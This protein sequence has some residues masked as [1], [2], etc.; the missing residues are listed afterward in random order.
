MT[1]SKLVSIESDALQPDGTRH[2]EKHRCTDISPDISHL[3]LHPT[4][5]GSCACSPVAARCSG[6][7]R[8]AGGGLPE[9]AGSRD[10]KHSVRSC[11]ALRATGAAENAFGTSRLG[12]S[13]RH[14]IQQRAQLVA[15]LGRH[16][17]RSRR[18]ES[19][20]QLQLDVAECA[21]D[22][23]FCMSRCDFSDREVEWARSLHGPPPQCASRSRTL[24]AG[25]S[26]R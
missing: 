10:Q 1:R 26:M 9:S 20:T 11:R 3:A 16:P 12:E 21:A 8:S 24:R 17:Y 25:S 23:T 18:L 15:R 4:E 22:H 7:A 13:A 2:R 19:E 5:V 6:A 14:V